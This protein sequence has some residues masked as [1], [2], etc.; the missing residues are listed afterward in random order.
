TKI[1]SDAI[2][3]LLAKGWGGSSNLMIKTESFKKVGGCDENVFVQ[4]YSIP[5]RIAGNHLKSSASKQYKVAV[6]NKLI[7]VCQ[8]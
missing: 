6:T 5:L 3:K 4:D 7:C 8:N 1:M 2:T